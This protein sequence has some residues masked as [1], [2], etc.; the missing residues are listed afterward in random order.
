[1]ELFTK[2]GF[3]IVLYVQCE[4]HSSNVFICLDWKSQD[5]YIYENTMD[6][7]SKFSMGFSNYVINFYVNRTYNGTIHSE[8][9][10]VIRHW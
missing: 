7:P 6:V 5:G 1:M 3:N 4:L 10:K 8:Y 2:A 9:D